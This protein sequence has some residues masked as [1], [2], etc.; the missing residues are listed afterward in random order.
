MPGIL[1]GVLHTSFHLILTKK[2]QRV[3][4]IH[5]SELKKPKPTEVQ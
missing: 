3:V 1:T 4:V 5:L 2:F